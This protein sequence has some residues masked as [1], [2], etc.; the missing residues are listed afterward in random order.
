MRTP[1]SSLLL[2]ASLLLPASAH[3]ADIKTNELP[4]GRSYISYRP[5]GLPEKH[6]VVVWIGKEGTPEAQAQEWKE[7][8][9]TIP[10]MAVF[11][12]P[13]ARGWRVYDWEAQKIHKDREVAYIREC[14]EHLE[15]EWDI[16]KKHTIVAGDANGADYAF[17]L[18]LRLP[19]CFSGSIPV[20]PRWCAVS[21]YEKKVKQA[22]VYFLVG[23]TDDRK[24]QAQDAHDRLRKN[25]S[26]SDLVWRPLDGLGAGM[27]PLDELARAVRWHRE[28]VGPYSDDAVDFAIKEFESGATPLGIHLLFKLSKDRKHGERAKKIFTKIEKQ[29]EKELDDAR[30]QPKFAQMDALWKLHDRYAPLPATYEGVK[31]SLKDVGADMPAAEAPPPPEPGSDDEAAKVFEL[32]EKAQT[33]KQDGEYARAIDLLKEM[34]GLV[35]RAELGAG[36]KKQL[37]IVG[38]YELARCYALNNRKNSSIEELTKAVELGF[39]DWKKIDGDK[40]LDSIRGEGAF[41]SL[42][43][44]RKKTE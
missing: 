39:D 22:R 12:T 3:G 43:A 15:R 33:H 44:K 42:S 8:F 7:K 16:E 6:L 30:R 36:E 27:P 24:K 37:Y 31:K 1:V 18:A 5:R 14:V 17:E 19:E 20:G 40:E 2:L 25:A 38:H 29:A 4:S 41:Q 21:R 9:A 23:A 13:D 35:D 28:L 32:A 26:G 10:V 34:L 11:P